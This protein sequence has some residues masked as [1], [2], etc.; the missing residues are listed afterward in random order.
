MTHTPTKSQAVPRTWIGFDLATNAEFWAFYSQSCPA[1]IDVL[2]ERCR[3][4][5]GEGYGTGGDDAY[6]DCQLAR[7]AICYV[8]AAAFSPLDGGR[9]LY[10][11]FR[12]DTYKPAP[13]PRRNLIKAAALI[14]A[15]IERLDRAEALA[16]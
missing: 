9:R 2:K 12:I 15:E 10:W 1:A 11:P 14:L 16:R 3:Q 6:T 4:I 8:R 13:D 5:D 7:A